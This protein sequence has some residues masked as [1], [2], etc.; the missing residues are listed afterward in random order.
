[1]DQVAA[2]A[3]P[4]WI[5]QEFDWSLIEPQPGTFDFSR[6]DQF[7]LLTA[8]HRVHV[9]PLLFVTPSWAGPSENSIPSDPSGYAAYVAAVVGRYGPH[10]SFWTQH[11]DLAGY[12]I[13][14]F[15]LWNEPYYDNGN[16]GE[17]DPGR[18]ARMVKAAAL[19]GR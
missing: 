5:R 12:A 19:A 10:G 9:L 7:M 14:T 13:Q 11:P 2:A 16:N 4:P 8:Q 18:Y 15:E 1:M 17:Y 3:A 6:Y